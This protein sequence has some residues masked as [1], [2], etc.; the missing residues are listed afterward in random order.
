MS[1]LTTISTRIT[2]DVM[3]LTHAR[4]KANGFHHFDSLK[5]YNN[6]RESISHATPEELPAGQ[7]DSMLRTKL[8]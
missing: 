1:A 8:R 5:L 4:N 6:T 7:H 2:T 3:H